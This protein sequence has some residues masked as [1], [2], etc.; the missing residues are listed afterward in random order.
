MS[1]WNVLCIYAGWCM[2]II[3]ALLDIR[4]THLDSLTLIRERTVEEGSDDGH[5]GVD[6]ITLQSSDKIKM[7]N[8]QLRSMWTFWQTSE[9]KH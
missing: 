2:V 5:E 3:C 8:T 4:V 9:H 1:V 6:H 7:E